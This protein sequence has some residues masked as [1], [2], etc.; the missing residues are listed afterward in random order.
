MKILSDLQHIVHLERRYLPFIDSREDRD[1]ATLVGFHDVIGR[2]P[3]TLKRLYLLDIAS[4]ATVQR[5]LARLVDKGVIVKR[6]HHEDRRAMT[7]HLSANAKREF[8]RFGAAFAA[9][10]GDA[11]H[12]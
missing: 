2:Q 11:T 6:P 10:N 9:G 12:K 5:R 3:L 4:I 7:L 1:I 8:Q